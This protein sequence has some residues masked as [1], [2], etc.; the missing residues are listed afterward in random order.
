M[1]LSDYLLQSYAPAWLSED[2]FVHAEITSEEFGV[3]WSAIMAILLITAITFT[4]MS[5]TVIACAIIFQVVA[6]I[7][8][9]TFVTLSVA[10][11]ATIDALVARHAHSHCVVKEPIIACACGAPVD[12]FVAEACC[13]VFDNFEADS[14][15]IVKRSCFVSPSTAGKSF[16]Q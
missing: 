6:M 11:F 14:E 5:A 7:A 3:P 4:V 13:R 8:R 15:M 1:L 12:S 2:E 9:I 10:S 16:F